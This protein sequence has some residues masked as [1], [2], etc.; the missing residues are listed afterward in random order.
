MEYIVAT[1]E[2]IGSKK[3]NDS[4]FISGE[5]EEIDGDIII[6]DGFSIPSDLLKH[7]HTSN[8]E[9]LGCI[10]IIKINKRT[11]IINLVSDKRTII[12]IY[13]YDYNGNF[14]I[15]NNPWLLAHL[16][17]EEIEIDEN[18]LLSQLV[19]WVDINPDRTLIKHLSRIKAGEQIEYDSK[20]KIIHA[21]NNY[22]FRYEPKE[23]V[24]LKEELDIADYQFTEYFSYIKE[25]NPNLVAG[26]GC[27]GGLDSRLIAHYTNKVGINT[28]YYVIGDSHPHKFL[29]SV[30]SIVSN[31]VAK[32]YNHEIKQ[33][34]YKISWIE[35]SL[36]L[37]IRNHPFFFSQVFLNPINELPEYDYQFV[38]DPGG[39]AYLAAPIMTNDSSKLKMHSDFFLG[40]RKDAQWGLVD[41]LRKMGGHLGF[42][43]DKYAEGS[44]LGLNRSLIDKTL[45]NNIIAQAREE[46]N[47][48][49]D[50]IPG[51]NNIEKWFYI[52]DN[53]VTRYMFA[54]AYGSMNRTKKS[55]PIYYPFFY[56]QIRH[57]PLSY[58]TDKFFLKNLLLHVNPNYASI[59]DQNLNYINRKNNI[60][61]RGINR[62]ELA[63]RGRG[64]QILDLMKTHEY[65]NLFKMVYLRKNPIFE[66]Y[67][68]PKLVLTS[69]L[70]FTYAGVQYL[71]LK[72]VADYIY[73]KDFDSLIEIK[74]FEMQ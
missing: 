52:Y 30:T 45:N 64:L 9:I 17:K 34:P 4:L 44:F 48:F 42:K 53:C 36:K 27:S 7:N 46:L 35:N 63:L 37:D 28:Q 15:S 1:K 74:E 70:P 20:N 67:V 19:Y 58:L 32:Y 2:F 18:S 29:K 66:K 8:E 21:K 33:I 40:L 13:K 72:M 62:A 49:I 3:I 11:G 43:F 69:Q 41:I 55:Y 57:F 38:G 23:N 12:P 26:F 65:R 50:N 5:F 47:D 14:G 10:N 56:E 39:Y 51:G 6:K 31:E 73:Y 60:L 68:D 61:T 16:F 25:H 24:S 54:A 71:K 22:N 59:P